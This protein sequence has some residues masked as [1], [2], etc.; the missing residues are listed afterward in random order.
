MSRYLV[1]LSGG[2]DSSVA[3]ALL[4]EQGHEVIGA[5]LRLVDDPSAPSHRS[6]CSQ[7]DLA[8]ARALCAQLDIPYYVFDLRARFDELVIQPFVLDYLQGR[9]PNPCVLCNQHFKF[10]ELL[11]RAL[12]QG[13]R[14]ATGHYA[15]LLQLQ[16]RTWLARACD[17]GKDQSYFLYRLSHQAIVSTDFPLGGLTKVEVRAHARRLALSV[18]HRPESQEVCFAEEGAATFVAGRAGRQVCAGVVRD[19][20]GQALGEHAGIHN[21]TIGQR[22]G[23]GIGGG[24]RRFV[25]AIDGSSGAVEVGPDSALFKRQVI[26]EQIQWSGE[27]DMD[28][29]ELRAKIRARHEPAA[30][31]DRKSVM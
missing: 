1:G 18:Q 12:A 28:T 25:T 10:G 8:A 30:V 2:V 6:C 4:V 7:E 19:E 15:R 16:G 31:R 21:F 13:A 17:R 24:P 14:L 11:Q 22:R 27:K 20:Q 23:L 29:K 9:T 26:L 5:S 3:A